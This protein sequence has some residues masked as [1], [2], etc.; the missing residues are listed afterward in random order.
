MHGQVFQR[1]ITRFMFVKF[2]KLNSLIN[3]PTRIPI[4]YF[5]FYLIGHSHRS[6][7]MRQKESNAFPLHGRKI[8]DGCIFQCFYYRNQTRNQEKRKQDKVDT[9]NHFTTYYYQ[10]LFLCLY[11]GTDSSSCIAFIIKYPHTYHSAQT[12]STLSNAPS[13]QPWL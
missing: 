2:F 5:G 4:K 6:I 9:K 3:R 10:R 13:T 7:G 1:N 8:F 12:V 11:R